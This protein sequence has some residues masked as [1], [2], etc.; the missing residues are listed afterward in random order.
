[1]HSAQVYQ[2]NVLRF[3]LHLSSF[4]ACLFQV[5]RGLTGPWQPRC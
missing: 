5:S 3:T 1:M 2:G 4:S